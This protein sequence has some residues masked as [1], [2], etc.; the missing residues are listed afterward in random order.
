VQA[1]QQHDFIMLGTSCYIG[2][3]FILALYSKIDYLFQIK[4]IDAHEWSQ[5]SS[6]RQFWEGR[7]VS[8]LVGL[9]AAR[10]WPLFKG[11]PDMRGYISLRNARVPLA[12]TA[13]QGN[14]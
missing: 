1:K 5:I 9:S 6:R 12:A 4:I 3:S 8:Q 2:Y 11:L 13:E 7:S 14:V 10:A